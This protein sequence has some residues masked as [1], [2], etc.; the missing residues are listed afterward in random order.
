MSRKF[1]HKSIIEHKVSINFYIFDISRLKNESIFWTFRF[2]QVLKMAP[3]ILDPVVKNSENNSEDN[4]TG[5]R[6]RIIG[7]DE[8]LSW[9]NNNNNSTELNRSEEKHKSNE[10]KSQ[11]K[12]SFKPQIRWP[13]LIAQVFIHGGSLY[14]LYYLVTL[15][16]ALYTYLWCEFS[17]QPFMPSSLLINFPTISVVL[18]VYATG[19]GITAGQSSFFQAEFWT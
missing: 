2:F 18:L 7:G 3:N 11:D 16:A 19:I 4:E 13:D 10:G 14:G 6:S 1:K 12:V 8:K 9:K 15:K 17:D 5:V